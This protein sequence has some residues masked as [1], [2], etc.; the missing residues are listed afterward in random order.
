MPGSDYD[1]FISHSQQD[2]ATAEA[3]CRELAV[4]DRPQVIANRDFHLGNVL[5]AERSPWLVIDPKPLAGEPAFDAGHLAL[6]LVSDRPTTDRAG[7]VVRT[8]A[9]SL[10]QSPDRVRAWA[11]VRAVENALW[12]AATRAEDP[13]GFVSVAV[14]LA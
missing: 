13:T 6:T 12:A 8:V 1:V 5:S 10:G 2:K 11:Y 4:P 9:A 3:I 7:A 14:A